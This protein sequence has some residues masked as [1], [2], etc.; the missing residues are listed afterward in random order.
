MTD[1]INKNTSLIELTERVRRL[2]S[3][4]NL[5]NRVTQTVSGDYVQGRLNTA[6]PLPT[7]STVSGDDQLYDRVLGPRY[8]YIVVDNGGT[9]EWRF[10][11][12]ELE[13]SWTPTV[14]ASTTPGTPSYNHQVGRYRR[15]GKTLIA[16]FSVQLNGWAGGPSGVVTVLGLPIASAAVP[17]GA[18]NMPFAGSCTLQMGVTL[19]SGENLQFRV[20]GNSAVIQLSIQSNIGFTNLTVAEITPA[21]FRVGGQV[22]YETN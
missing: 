16:D 14:T 22:I 15:Y 13:G 12:F 6:R 2:E 8:E 7:S 10:V 21:N 18:G 3:Q 5:V 19:A 11:P 4:L 9:P 1:L 17:I 20:V